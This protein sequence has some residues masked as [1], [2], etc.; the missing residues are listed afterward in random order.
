MID[1]KY[2]P[3]KKFVVALSIAIAIILLA[4]IF[5]FWRSNTTNYVNGDLVSTTD[6][7]YGIINTD[8]DN[9]GLPDWKEGLYGTDPKKTDTDGDGTSDFDEIS[10]NRDAL[11]ANTA[12]N[13]EEPTDKID[14]QIIEE[15]KK[16]LE[17]YEKLNEIDRFSRNLVSNVIASQP[18]S[19]SL[20]EYTINSIL[21][22]SLSDLPVKKYTGVTKITDLNLLKTDIT[23]LNKNMIDYVKGFASQS[24]M[25]APIIGTDMDLI[26][27]YISNGATS[28][29]VELLK[30]TDKYQSIVNNLVKMPL[31]VAIGYYDVSY[32]LKIIN[33][34]EIIIAI[35]K[36]IAN[37][38]K[39]SLNIFS[40]LAIY[41][42]TIKDLFSTMS[43]IDSIL[44]I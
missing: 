34:L 19:G 16:A 20:D 40:N 33:D 11:K 43:T 23:N 14:P 35:D 13:N 31:P 44:K 42:S 41:N 29:R 30:L 27:S 4:I 18:I 24:L 6:T 39:D 32:H 22:K 21:S 28:T 9:D 15:N 7:T 25:L 36:D 5:N 8:T 10:Q 2:L 17:E 26:G 3:S 1:K 12:I 37:S 38:D